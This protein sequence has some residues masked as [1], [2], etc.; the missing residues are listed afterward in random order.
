MA[1]R[2]GSG[3]M[4]GEARTARMRVGVVLPIDQADGTVAPPTYPEIREVARAA[5]EAG[6]D[7]LWVFDH[8]LFRFDG[9]TAGI[10]ECWTILSAIAEAT[11]RVQLGSIVMCTSFRNPALLAKMAA[12]LDHVSDGRLILG[13]GCGWHDPEYTAFGYPTDHKV[14]R[15]E[16]S[17]TVIRDLI[18]EGRADLAGRW[19]TADDAVLLPPARPDLPILIAAKRP[20]MLELTAR[21]ADAWNLAWFGVPDERLAKGRADL[22]EACERVGRDPATLEITVGVTVRYPDL[23]PVASTPPEPPAADAPPER[24]L[25]GSVAGIAAGLS[26]HAALGTGHLIAALEPT[27]PES[28]RQLAE[29]VAL[30]RAAVAAS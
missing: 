3:D 9:K 25:T 15:F 11:S 27:T 24:V 23:M 16:E 17:L 30:S 5:E 4:A 13:I 6:L 22:A 28:V 29:S 19:V 2:G 21:H 7:S 1:M 12:T 14:G 8:L 26:A 20:R 18:R 10:H